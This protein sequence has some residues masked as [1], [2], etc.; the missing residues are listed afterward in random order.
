VSGVYP[1]DPNHAIPRIGVID[2]V[3]EEDNGDLLC[4]LIIAKPLGSDRESLSRMVQK[5][6]NYIRE[7]GTIARDHRVRVDIVVHPLSD[8]AALKVIEECCNWMRDSA[9]LCTVS[10]LNLTENEL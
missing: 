9:I 3:S 6:E 10:T 5:A 1:D 7:L 8:P 2:L 4:G